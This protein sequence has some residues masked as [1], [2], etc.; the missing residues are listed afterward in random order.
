MRIFPLTALFFAL[1]AISQLPGAEPPP[2]GMAWIPGGEFSMGLVAPGMENAQPVHRVKVD[3]FWIDQTEV[4]N[5]AFAEFVKESGYVT[6]AERKVSAEEFPELTEEQ[7]QPGSIV[8]TPPEGPVPLTDVRQ[9][10]AW[11]TG[12]DWC[13]PEGP[14][15]TIEGKDN[16][17]V[18]QVTWDDAQAYAKW[19]GKRLP[20]EAEWEYAARGGLE[21][22]PYVWGDDF[23]P[24]GKMMANIF[25]GTFPSENT[26]ADGYPATSPVKSFPA[27]GYGLYDMAGNVWEWTHDWYRPD[28]YEGLDKE[29]TVNPRGPESSFDPRE[30]GVAKRVH[31]GGSFLCTDQYC[32]RYMPGGRGSGELNSSTDH[33]GFRLVKDAPAPSSSPE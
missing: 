29:V 9:W 13:H 33:L 8:F 26:A 24:D 28:T 5:A 14:E 7:R 12:A 4:T 17:P 30:P 25:Q 31:K 3:G 32:S 16:Y 15:S 11:K 10:W 21:G 20:T 1:A 27:N 18:V 19:A 6:T 22:K 23:M 2:A